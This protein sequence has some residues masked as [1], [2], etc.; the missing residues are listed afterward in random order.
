VTGQDARQSD[1]LGYPGT[2]I[3]FDDAALIRVATMLMLV[4]AR[5]LGTRDV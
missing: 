5:F 4:S 1:K 3:G 2:I